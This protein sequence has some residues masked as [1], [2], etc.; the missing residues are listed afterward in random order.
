MALRFSPAAR[1]DLIGIGD[2]IAARNPDA[3]ARFTEALD[4]RC[5]QLARRPF[6]GV[7]RPEIRPDL[8][9]LTFRS[10]LILY[11]VTGPDVEIVR[12]VHGARHLPGM[13][14]PD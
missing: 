5:R 9:L 7:A 1:A 6:L 4:R 14:E 2:Y 10:Y 8:R 11:R 3:A 13:F 12:V